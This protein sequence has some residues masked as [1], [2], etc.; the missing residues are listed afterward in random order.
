M[1]NHGINNIYQINKVISGT[2]LSIAIAISWGTVYSILHIGIAMVF[3][4]SLVFSIC[5]CSVME[6]TNSITDIRSTNRHET[7]YLACLTRA[8]DST[9][10]FYINPFTACEL[11]T[12]IQAKM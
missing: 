11:I 4:F 5:P 7:W 6:V 8:R 10:K 3:V 1:C 9:T 12:A 2:I